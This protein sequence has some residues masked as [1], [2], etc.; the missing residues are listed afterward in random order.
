MLGV[1]IDVNHT[2]MFFADIGG[3]NIF[4]IKGFLNYEYTSIRYEWYV[5]DGDYQV[6][7]NGPLT[8]FSEQGTAING[9]GYYG[10]VV[11]LTDSTGRFVT[12]DLTGNE[13]SNGFRILNAHFMLVTGDGFLHLAAN[14]GFRGAF[15][16]IVI[17]LD[18]GEKIFER[19]MPFI[20][21]ENF[22]QLINPNASAVN[23]A[24]GAVYFVNN[25]NAVLRLN[26]GASVVSQV[27]KLGREVDFKLFPSQRLRTP[28]A[29]D[30]FFDGGGNMYI[31]SYNRATGK[32][33][34]QKF[35]PKTDGAP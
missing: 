17:D 32:T 4:I 33:Y 1:S 8:V 35:M 18:T 6:L 28:R 25:D 10:G 3:G 21:G 9:F 29:N 27:L 14:S 11:Y 19:S 20:Y 24:D 5:Y 30:M 7:S 22:W 13:V 2:N 31:S 34:I 16:Y 12:I 23:P 15:S 26:Q